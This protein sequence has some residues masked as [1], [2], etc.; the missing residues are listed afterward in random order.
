MPIPP[1]FSK[2]HNLIGLVSTCETFQKY[3]KT[4]L[5]NGGTIPEPVIKAFHDCTYFS[6]P[7]LGLSF[8]FHP[9]KTGDTSTLLLDSIDVYNGYTRDGFQPFCGDYPC[10]L[11]ATME[12]HSIVE[13]FGE[14]DRKGGGGKTRTPCWI[15]YQFESEKDTQTNRGMIIQLHGIDWDDRTMGWTSVALF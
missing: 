9:N 2:E 1:V 4:I 3:L 10:G 13:R 15:E 11:T 5:P 6:Y 12:A 14:P 7:T 8:C